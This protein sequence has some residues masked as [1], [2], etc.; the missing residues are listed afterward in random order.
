MKTEQIVREVIA[1][2]KGID[3]DGETMQY[4]ID[5]V[6]MTQQMQR[7]LIL[8]NSVVSTQDLLDELIQ[9]RQK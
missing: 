4:I 5:E 2:L 3:I 8:S 7:Q 6:G 1:K 9:Y